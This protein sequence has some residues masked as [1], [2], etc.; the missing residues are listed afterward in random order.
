MLPAALRFLAAVS[1]V[2]TDSIAS[3][4]HIIVQN[5]PNPNGRE[6]IF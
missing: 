2:A 5:G 6:G 4:N 3:K 1:L